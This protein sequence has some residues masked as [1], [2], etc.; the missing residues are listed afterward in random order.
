MSRTRRPLSAFAIFLAGALFVACGGDGSIPM[1]PMAPA[2]AG[3]L[4]VRM[5]DAPVADATA[6]R[7]H[8]VGLT[9]KRSGAP[10]ERIANDIGTV[11]LLALE[12]T[13]MLLATADVAAGQ[14]EFIRVEL[15]EAGSSI[16]EAGSGEVHPLSIASDEIK[17]NGGF[18][19]HANG[20]TDVLL[21][22]DA[23]ASLRHLGNDRW[24][25]TPV[26]SQVSQS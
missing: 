6:I 26:I 10:V 18:T 12:N 25:L 3:T 17:V 4:A 5:T 2:G 13:S 9:V 23:R 8:I 1:N 21:D 22:F 14:Y 24:L 11:D 7:V 16:V 20:T 19:V 15:S